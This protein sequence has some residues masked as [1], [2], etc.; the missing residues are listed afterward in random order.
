MS[1]P[2][3]SSGSSVSSNGSSYQLI[4]DHI[5]T[6]PGSYEIPLK[7]MYSLNCAPKN[8]ASPSTPT[9]N[10]TS[11]NLSQGSFTPDTQSTASLTESLMS[12]LSQLSNQQQTLPPSFITAFV[13]RCFTPQLPHVDFPQALT[14]LDYLKDLETRRRREAASAMSRLGIDRDALDRD[15]ASLSPRN[16]QWVRSLE[17]KEKKIDTLYTQVWIGLR[18]WILINELSLQPFHKHNCVAMLNTLYPPAGITEQ[19]QPTTLLTPAVLKSQRDGFFK[20][21]QAVEKSG[22]RILTN[23]MQQ[24]KAPHDNNGWEA[25]VRNLSVYLQVANS[26]INECIH[27]GVNVATGMPRTPTKH[28]RKAD[29]SASFDS[30]PET[31][32]RGRKKAD[33]GVSFGSAAS[34]ENLRRRLDSTTSIGATSIAES[35]IIRRDSNATPPSPSHSV[36]PKTPSGGNRRG[37]GMERLARGLKSIG[38]SRTEATEMIA[39]YEIPAAAPAQ[40]RPLLRKMRSLGAL[41]ERKTSGLGSRQFSETPAF[42]VDAMR[43]ERALIEA[44][45]AQGKTG[46]LGGNEV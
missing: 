46:K 42:D 5:L 28:V 36:R 38:R 1:T 4:L 23:L 30:I 2:N 6:Y 12:Q 18:R 27:V 7:T 19:A 31:E 14:G 20:Y 40:D 9:S 3:R 41:S 43:R 37:T 8:A 11:P 44:R 25:V 45:M 34:T 15:V 32:Q 35:S 39:D 16:L 33:S 29:S 13:Q 22:P 24:G 17:E 10:G 21:V 26:M